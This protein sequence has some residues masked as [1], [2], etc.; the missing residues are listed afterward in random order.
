MKEFAVN[1]KM[2]GGLELMLPGVYY[3]TM[4]EM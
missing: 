1:R 4:K 3:D 2:E